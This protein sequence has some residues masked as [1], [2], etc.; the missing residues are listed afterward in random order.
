MSSAR[1]E[2]VLGWED[3]IGLELDIFTYIPLISSIRTLHMLD[4]LL[5][6][7]RSSSQISQRYGNGE[8]D[9]QV[10]LGFHLRVCLRGR[11]KGRV[12]CC[13]LALCLAQ[14]FL[15]VLVDLQHQADRRGLGTGR[16]CPQGSC[17]LQQRGN[18][19]ECPPGAV[20]PGGNRVRDTQV[21]PQSCSPPVWPGDL[22][23]VCLS[24]PY[25]Q[26]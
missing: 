9:V 13:S 12:W 11:R 23:K 10:E 2:L 18:V 14:L 3:K 25:C 22:V 5:P 1:T 19:P 7:E 24:F 17:V 8:Q 26:K 16:G 6:A 15:T 20:P 21:P 4:F